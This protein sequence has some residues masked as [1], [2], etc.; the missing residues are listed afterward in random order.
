MKE[1]LP[2]NATNDCYS[3]EDK[4]AVFAALKEKINESP[5][6]IISERSLAKPS[7]VRV[8][9]I[10]YIINLF[11]EWGYIRK[12]CVVESGAY[13]RYTFEIIEDYN[14]LPYEEKYGTP[15][16]GTE[17]EETLDIDCEIK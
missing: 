4:E 16:Y 15:V 11:I 12:R 14:K 8:N 3:L 17:C 2:K 9:T 5:G 6:S 1:Y 13:K 10:R 7:G